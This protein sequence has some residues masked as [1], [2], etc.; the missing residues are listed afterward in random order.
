M[1]KYVMTMVMRFEHDDDLPL[2]NVT[3]NLDTME[4]VMEILEKFDGPQDE[5]SVTVNFELQKVE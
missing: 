5:D 1:T 2:M 3:G 4:N